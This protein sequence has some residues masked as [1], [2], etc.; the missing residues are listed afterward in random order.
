MEPMIPRFIIELCPDYFNDNY[1]QT[2]RHVGLW[3]KKK[4]LTTLNVFRPGCS[5]QNAQQISFSSLR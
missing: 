1:I 3:N 5:Q 2:Y 4:K